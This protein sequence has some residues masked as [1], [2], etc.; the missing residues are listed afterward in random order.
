MVVRKLNHGKL[1]N[2]IDQSTRIE[3]PRKAYLGGK[4][5]LHAEYCRASTR[6]AAL[7]GELYIVVANNEVVSTASWFAP[8]RSL[9][10]T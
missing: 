2:N 6:A 4:W 3:L 7:E 10:G 5:T 1:A 8:G 9:Q